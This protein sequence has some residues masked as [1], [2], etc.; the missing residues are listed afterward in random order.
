[1]QKNIKYTLDKMLEITSEKGKIFYN[2]TGGE[3][4]EMLVSQVFMM[5][6]SSALEEKGGKTFRN[7][8]GM[9]AII[10]GW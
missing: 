3:S 5:K 2:W 8:E 10:K 1:M 4:H 7:T 9:V 6:D